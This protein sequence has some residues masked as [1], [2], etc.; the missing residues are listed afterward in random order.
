MSNLVSG[1]WKQY[2]QIPISS[3][4]EGLHLLAYRLY[5]FLC[6]E[7]NVHSAPVLQFSNQ[8]LSAAIGRKDHK[9]ICR[10]RKEFEEAG[11]IAC[12]RVPPGIYEY[13]MLNQFRDQIPTPKGR[14]G[15][16][17]YSSG[18]GDRSTRVMRD[19]TSEGT[20]KQQESTNR[21]AKVA[22]GTQLKNCN[23]H[24][25]VT[26]WNREGELICEDCHPNPRAFRPPTA[27][28]LG[29]KG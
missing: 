2:F 28:E 12:R 21:S 15:L 1:Q 14:R 23:I 9:A 4:V 22:I 24:G 20:P 11:L 19:L 10:A 17:I 26:H 25:T 27:Y 29:F 3:S 16:R 18:W 6:K 5:A 8:E 7:V 13:K